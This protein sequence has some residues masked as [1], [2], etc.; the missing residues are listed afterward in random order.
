MEAEAVEVAVKDEKAGNFGAMGLVRSTTGTGREAEAS[1]SITL[2][3]CDATLGALE[4]A[5]LYAAKDGDNEKQDSPLHGGRLANR[6]R[7]ATCFY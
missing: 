3:N 4:V 1:G 5:K 2:G 6:A 7:F